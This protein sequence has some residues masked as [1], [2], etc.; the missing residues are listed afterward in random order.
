M[1]DSA[2]AIKHHTS[3]LRKAMEKGDIE[4]AVE[5]LLHLSALR[6]I[7]QRDPLLRDQLRTSSQKPL[8]QQRTTASWPSQTKPSTRPTG[9]SWGDT[10]FCRCGDGLS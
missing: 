1:G 8:H 3:L 2:A 9:H 5:H 7:Q 6:D 10:L 4:E